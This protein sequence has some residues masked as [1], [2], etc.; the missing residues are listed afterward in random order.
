MVMVMVMVVVVMVMVVMVV[1]VVMVVKKTGGLVHESQRV[2]DSAQEVRRTT[3]T[4]PP[5]LTNKQAQLK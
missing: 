1:V 5:T 3:T 4:L 2:G